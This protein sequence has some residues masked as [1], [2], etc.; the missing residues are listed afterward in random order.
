MWS[1]DSGGIGGAPCRDGGQ[2]AKGHL[3]SMDGAEGSQTYQYMRGIDRGRSLRD[4]AAE[5]RKPRWLSDG[6]QESVCVLQ[7]KNFMT[8]C[9]V[10]ASP[11]ELICQI[12]AR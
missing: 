11:G 3:H 5:E 2:R 8:T 9:D 4:G 7:W 12:R 1:T 10:S 6:G